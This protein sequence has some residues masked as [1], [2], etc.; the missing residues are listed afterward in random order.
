M[1]ESP[2]SG[3]TLNAGTT[4]PAGPAPK[5]AEVPRS[6]KSRSP[7]ELPEFIAHYR[8]LESLGEGGMGQV[9]KAEQREPIRRIVALKVIKLGMDTKEVVARFDAERQALA[10]MNHPNV[11]RVF[12]A[13]MT[14]TG[15]PYFAMEHVPGVPL[16]DYCDQTKLTTR[17]RL[18]LFIPVCHAI[19][20][21]HQKGIIHRDLKPSNI[22]VTVFDGKPVPKVIDFGIAKATNQQLTQHTLFTQTGALIGTPE[23]MSPEQAQTSGLDVDTRTDVYSLGVILYELLTGALP[24]DTETLHRA[25]LDGMAKMIREEEPQKPSTKLGILNKTPTPKPGIPDTHELARRRRC[26]FRTLQRELRGDLDWIVLKAMEKDRIRRYETASALADDVQK[27]LY[28]EPVSA[29]QPGRWYRAT[30]FARRNRGLFVTGTIVGFTVIVGFLTSSIG[31]IKFWRANTDLAAKVQEVQHANTVAS[32]KTAEALAQR[33]EAEKQRNAAQ[34]AVADG[35]LAQGDALDLAGRWVDAGGKYAEAYTSLGRLG[36]PTLGAELGLWAHYAYSPPPLLAL[37]GSTGAVRCVAVSK[38]GRLAIS[39]GEDR[40][41]RLWDVQSGTEIRSFVGH[42]GHVLCLAISA[43]GKTAL[44]GSADKTIGLWDVQTGRKLK[45]L[46]GHA[47]PVS[48]VCF[49]PDGKSV[50]SASDDRTLKLWNLESGAVVRTFSTHAQDVTVAFSPDGKL[51]LSGSGVDKLHEP[52]LTLWNV[53]QGTEIRSFP[54]HSAGVSSIAF[55]S[56]GTKALAG[57]DDHTM[58]LWDLA[59][60]TVVQKFVGH[61]GGVNSVAFSPDDSKALSA[62]DDNTLKVWDVKTGVELRSLRGHT[63]RVLAA[64]YVG[65]G[66]VALSGSVDH[67]LQ[68]W[69]LRPNSEIRSLHGHDGF[70]SALAFSPDGRTALSGGYDNSVIHWDISTGLELHRLKGHTGAVLSVAFSPDGKTAVSGGADQSAELWDLRTGL[71][72]Q[73]LSGHTNAVMGVAFAPDGRSVLTA[74]ADQTIKLWDART[75]SELRT[76]KG[77]TGAITSMVFSPADGRTFATAG[78]DKLI[79]L[80]DIKTGEVVRTLAGHTGRVLSLAISTDG[81]LLASGSDDKTIRIW[82]IA[83][84]KELRSFPAHAGAVLSVAF[85]PD[86]IT[87]LSGGEDHTLKLWDAQTGTLLRAFGGQTGAVLSVALAADGLTALSASYDDLT[88]KLWSFGRGR[89]YFT[90]LP[91]VARAQEALHHDPRDAEAAAELGRWYAFR[92]RNDWAIEQLT[93]ARTGGVK[94]SPLL[95]ARINWRA[96]RRAQAV[97]EFT[98]ALEESRDDQERF[99]LTLCI[100]GLK[101]AQSAAER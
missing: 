32:Q 96:G 6:A 66:S 92:G 68:L 97:R 77:A 13:G 95:M 60:S 17:E 18:E 21:A 15:R 101:A 85:A 63:G 72:Q 25:G 4:R 2:Q 41:V 54:S 53:D 71:E 57:S 8:I 30:K 51:A 19:Q 100:D 76:F 70:G 24:F 64:A 89:E 74:S 35:L 58:N 42:D 20:H 61:T 93:T 81:R 48:N 56:D 67:T 91:Q 69:D 3:D 49:S 27:Y 50:L 33:S 26:D 10:L 1:S 88:I 99:Y 82:D 65:D 34:I 16:T 9:Y 90:L 75:G 86:G 55:S 84:G 39:G 79:R 37:T 59:T 40:V 28:D 38:D 44:S 23:Y 45:Q 52:T 29:G 87:V 36:R 47:G 73:P 31:F 62:A 43:D 11:A 7:R 22:L 80:W 12:E 98:Q 83:A 5:A 78:E 94:I 14:D 46:E